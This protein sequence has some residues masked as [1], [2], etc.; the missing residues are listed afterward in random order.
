MRDG[1]L[2]WKLGKLFYVGIGVP[3]EGKG[4]GSFVNCVK[5]GEEEEGY[6]V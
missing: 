3:E 5:R 2:G 4:V 6:N 1:T